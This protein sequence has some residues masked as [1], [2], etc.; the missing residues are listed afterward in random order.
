MTTN[1]D[2]KNSATSDNTDSLHKDRGKNA[3]S[4]NN[5]GN[6]SN[7]NNNN[8][9]NASILIDGLSDRIKQKKREVEQLAIN[10]DD[11]L[12]ELEKRQPLCQ[13]GE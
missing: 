3:K 9:N 6:R 2:R 1:E 5:K 13:E 12:E 8:N 11:I 10:P 7:N 4:D